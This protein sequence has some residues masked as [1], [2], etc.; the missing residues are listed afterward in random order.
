MLTDAVS[1]PKPALLPGVNGETD[2]DGHEKEQE[3]YFRPVVLRVFYDIV[4]SV[5]GIRGES[6]KVCRGAAN[7]RRGRR[8]VHIASG[9]GYRTQDLVRT[10]VLKT[11]LIWRLLLAAR[12]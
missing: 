11:F 7:D 2:T 6:L 12:V 10:A 3:P 4:Y 1:N 9:L 8:W 5:S